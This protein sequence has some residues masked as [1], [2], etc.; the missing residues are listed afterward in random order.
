MASLVPNGRRLSQS[1]GLGQPGCHFHIYPILSQGRTCKVPR[2][3]TLS[4]LRGLDLDTLFVAT[5]LMVDINASWA[6]N[7]ILAFS[8][9]ESP[10]LLRRRRGNRNLVGSFDLCMHAPPTIIWPLDTLTRHL[11]LQDSFLAPC[12]RSLAESNLGASVRLPMI[13]EVA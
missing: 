1:Q 11:L 9:P 10:C 8:A 13:A 5:M 6:P 2:R 7:S 12:L 3:N 4:H